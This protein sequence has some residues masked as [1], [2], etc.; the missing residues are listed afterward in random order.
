M[1][2]KAGRK[3]GGLRSRKDE[4]GFVVGSK[5]SKAAAKFASAKGATMKEVAKATGHD[6]Y[7][8]IRALKE[9][10]DKVERIGPRYK[11]TRGNAT[12]IQERHVEWTQ[13]GPNG[14]VVIPAAFRQR[15][16]IGPRD[17]V[18]MRIVEDEL[19]L[20]GRTRALRRAQELVAKY[21][22][23]GTSLVDELIADRRREVA[24]EEN[25]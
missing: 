16:G 21:V 23:P 20:V 17:W 3:T 6:Q 13:I 5:R 18:Q 12:A 14:R 19:R 10:G 7:N 22:P 4:Y 11:L 24:D 15:L 25:Q 2:L 1:K 8:V 9:R